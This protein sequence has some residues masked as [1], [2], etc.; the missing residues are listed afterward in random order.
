MKHGIIAR[1]RMVA[2]NVVV[3]QPCCYDLPTGFPI[4]RHNIHNRGHAK[5]PP[6]VV[7][8]F[9]PS[10]ATMSLHGPQICHTLDPITPAYLYN[11]LLGP[12]GSL[13]LHILD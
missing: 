8:W 13:R 3:V 9:Q 10:C 1:D 6:A 11:M 4:S 7:Q 5:L 2:P 12:H